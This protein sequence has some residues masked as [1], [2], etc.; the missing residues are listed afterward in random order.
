[1]VRRSGDTAIVIVWVAELAATNGTLL[2]FPEYLAVIGVLPLYDDIVSVQVDPHVPPLAVSVPGQPAVVLDPPVQSTW[3][4]PTD[5][6]T[7]TWNV[8]LAPASA[9]AGALM[10]LT[11]DVPPTYCWNCELSLGRLVTEPE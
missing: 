5:P 3:P 4:A 7:A 8:T 1:M 10:N 9:V 2:V 11:V 6:S